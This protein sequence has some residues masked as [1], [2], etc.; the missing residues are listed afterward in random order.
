M[1]SDRICR[2]SICGLFA[3]ERL[4]SVFLFG[5]G[6]GTPV[7]CSV[8]CGTVVEEN[9]ASGISRTP[10]S[11]DRIPNISMLFQLVG[12]RVLRFRAYQR[13]FGT[14]DAPTREN[15]IYISSTRD[16]GIFEGERVLSVSQNY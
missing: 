4:L 6:T 15:R 8:T 14:P 10:C 7:F 2:T 11:T 1:D 9:P 13:T 5:R 3:Y 16:S 12:C